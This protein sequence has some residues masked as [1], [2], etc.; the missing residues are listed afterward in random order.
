ME[1]KNEH[2]AIALKTRK[3][4]IDDGSKAQWCM[5]AVRVTKAERKRLRRIEV[6]KEISLQEIV[7]QALDDYCKKAGYSAQ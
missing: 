2:P 4:M 5:L 7:R 1:T 6:D 3:E